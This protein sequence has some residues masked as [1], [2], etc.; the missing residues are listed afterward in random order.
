MLSKWASWLTRKWTGSGAAC[1]TPWSPGALHRPLTHNHHAFTNAR[2]PRLVCVSCACRV[3]SCRVRSG[4]IAEFT[5]DLQLDVSTT[6]LSPPQKRDMLVGKILR[7]LLS[8]NAEGCREFV[9]LMGEMLKKA[10]EEDSEFPW[11]ECVGLFTLLSVLI[12]STDIEPFPTV[13]PHATRTTHTHDT[14]VTH[15]Y[16]H[17][18]TTHTH[19][20]TLCARGV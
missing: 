17:T 9:K 12:R 7:H 8:N 4:L 10:R 5:S 6:T 18:H 14:H 3:V 2:A 20:L 13:R 11:G 15:T 16:T 19:E 1:S